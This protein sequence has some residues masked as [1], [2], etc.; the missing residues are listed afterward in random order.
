MNNTPLPELPPRADNP[1]QVPFWE[2]VDAGYLA[3]QRCGRCSHAFLPAREECPKCLA[4]SLVWERA[5]G[6]AKLVSWVVYYRAFNPAFAPRV[7]YVVA[8]VE[9]DEGPRMITNIVDAEDPEELCI[10]QRLRL[11]V[12]TDGGTKVPRFVESD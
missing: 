5:S 8:V 11:K 12:E 3:F 2:A 4:A 7:P 9:L 6:D 10:D 1:L